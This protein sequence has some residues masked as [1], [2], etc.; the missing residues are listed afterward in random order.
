MQETKIFPLISL[1]VKLAKK[2][3]GEFEEEFVWYKVGNNWTEEWDDIDLITQQEMLSF[4][5][6]Y[7]ELNDVVGISPEELEHLLNTDLK[8]YYFDDNIF[9]ISVNSP[10]L[11]SIKTDSCLIAYFILFPFIYNSYGFTNTSF[12]TSWLY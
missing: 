11:F 10:F 1:L 7:D 8:Y 12:Y 6:N 3:F 9:V 4:K 2:E 5:N